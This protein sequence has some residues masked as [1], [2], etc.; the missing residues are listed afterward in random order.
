MN[1]TYLYLERD[2]NFSKI[3]EYSEEVAT[4]S[5]EFSRLSPSEAPRGDGQRQ[6]D[7]ITSLDFSKFS[8]DYQSHS[9]FPRLLN[10]PPD[11]VQNVN[12]FHRLLGT[13]PPEEPP[14]I[15]PLA[16]L[17]AQ[18]PESLVTQ[19]IQRILSQNPELLAT[20]LRQSPKRGPDL[21]QDNLPLCLQTAVKIFLNA[22]TLAPA[23][24]DEENF[25]ANW[26]Q[27]SFKITAAAEGGGGGGGQ[28]PANS[29]L[30]L[31]AA[32]LSL[33]IPNLSNMTNDIQQR[34]FKQ[35][36]NFWQNSRVQSPASQDMQQGSDLTPNSQQQLTPN[37]QSLTPSQQQPLTPTLQHPPQ[38]QTPQQQQQQASQQQ[39]QQQQQQSQQQNSQQHQQQLTP[40]QQQMT[41]TPQQ[42]SQNQ[43][44]QLTPSQQQQL[45]QVQQ[46]LNPGQMTPGAGGLPQMLGG[47]PDH[48][49][50]T[51][52][53]VNEIQVS[54]VI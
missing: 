43:S 37:Q 35:S 32:P 49:M 20:A 30:D 13:Q 1:L 5:V 29:A 47:P 2:Q 31:R 45:A 11:S 33:Q 10:Q 25:V 22:D 16:R 12:P 14:E 28:G 38:A 15:N 36:P 18:S 54:H 4:E 19:N 7:Q 8:Q 51:E 46:Q 9:A 26:L 24:V 17:L 21:A 48:K 50:M 41:P 52:K 34:Q 6:L 39:Q 40:N 23:K 27:N 44:H 42:M 53:L 3:E